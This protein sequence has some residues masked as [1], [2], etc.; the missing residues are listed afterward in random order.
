MTRAQA[1]TLE[2]KKR[3]LREARE[4]L[5]GILT[6]R[7]AREYHEGSKG[8]ARHEIRLK[9]LKDLIDALEKEIA[10]LEGKGPMRAVGTVQRDW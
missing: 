5:S 4:E 1:E 3:L 8:A 7:V 6:N 2:W 9:E 10:M